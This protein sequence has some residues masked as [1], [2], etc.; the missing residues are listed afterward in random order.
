MPLYDY[1][2]KVCGKTFEALSCISD[3][4]SVLCDCGGGCRLLISKP[5]FHPFPEGPWEHLDV[6]PVYI[7]SKKQLKR[8]CDK[9]GLSSVYLMDS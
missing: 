6:E 2:C 4:R 1:E 5:N 3:R 9:R 8:E 7:S